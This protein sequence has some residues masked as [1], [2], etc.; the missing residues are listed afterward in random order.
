MYCGGGDEVD[1]SSVR[2]FHGSPVVSRSCSRR[3]KLTTSW[4]MKQPMPRAISS[5]PSAAIWNHGC[6]EGSSKWFMRR[7]T[8]RKPSQY[9]GMNAT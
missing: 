8:P 2:P 6:S 4:M 3:M 7:V 5:A 1:H 9:S